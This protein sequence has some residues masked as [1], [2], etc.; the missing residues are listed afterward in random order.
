MSSRVKREPLTTPNALA[1]RTAALIAATSIFF[2]GI[3]ASKARLA[4][5][6][7]PPP[8]FRSIRAAVTCHEMPHLSLHQPALAFLPTVTDNGVPVAVRFFSDCQFAIWKSRR[9][10]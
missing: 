1:S 7:H 5:F 4:A 6:C 3:I 8:V 10:R 2:I 9:P